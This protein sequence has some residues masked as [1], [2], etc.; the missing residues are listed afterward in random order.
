[1]E[2]THEKAFCF[3]APWHLRKW[4]S[5]HEVAT[6]RRRRDVVLCSSYG[7][8]TDAMGIRRSGRPEPGFIL[9]M[10]GSLCFASAE[11]GRESGRTCGGV[12]PMKTL[13]IE[14]VARGESR[15]SGGWS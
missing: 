10:R 6:A 13:V 1:M 14:A 5:G 4:T 11:E 12:K 15:A 3:G 8:D 7:M 9:S 2:S